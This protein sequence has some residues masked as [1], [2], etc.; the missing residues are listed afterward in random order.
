[1]TSDA[2][3]VSGPTGI[4]TGSPLFNCERGTATFAAVPFRFSDSFFSASGDCSPVSEPS[5]SLL[6]LDSVVPPVLC[7]DISLL[8]WHNLYQ[9]CTLR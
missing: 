4:G 6:L 3:D 8:Q 5:D 2:S 7:S 1:M 9:L